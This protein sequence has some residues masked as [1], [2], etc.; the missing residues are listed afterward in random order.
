MT[1]VAGAGARRRPFALELPAVACTVV[2]LG[3][4]F[5]VVYPLLLVVLESFQVA[6][7]GQPARYGLDGWRAAFAEPL[8]RTALLNTF[9]VT[10]ARQV[11]SLALAV[12]IAWLIARTDLPGRTWIEFAFWGA[13]FLPTLTV[14]LSWILLLDPDYG[15]INTGLA[16]LP[17]IGK[18][19]FDIYSFWG[20]VW[21]HVITGSL[22]VKVILLTPAFRNMNAAF[23]EASRVAGAGTT[24]TALS[25]TIP[26]MAPVVLSV[27]LL[28]TMVSL[29]TFE[30]EQVL[31]VPFRFFVFSTMIY[32]LL[33][34]RVP[35]Y[36]A[37]TALAVLVL[38]AMLPLG[39]TPQWLTRGRRYTT[40]T[41][42]FQSRRH[43]LGRWRWPAVALLLAPVVIVLG[44]PL[45][46]AGL[47]ALIELFG[48]FYIPAPWTLKN[49]TTVLADELFLRSLWNTVVLAGS[50]AGA[51]VLV[52]SLIAFIVVRTRFVGRRAVHLLSWVPV[53]GPGVRLGL[54]LL[55]LFLGVG[56][57]RPP[58]GSMA[59]LG[60]A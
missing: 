10:L 8:L 47:G 16:K 43:R 58:F 20:I 53:T 13:F 17:V 19:P 3:V 59:A 21:I 40:I 37:A 33:V 35:R 51:A 46:V 48:V 23:E 32:D 52:P 55:W 5:C 57:P 44:V 14:T 30:V 49:W 11:V 56:V 39:F 7:P 2:L 6:P 9:K 12:L 28:G 34:T 38:A 29:Q 27:F 1:T 42:Q 24:R 41:G 60:L 18:G 15:L 31:G 54:A 36:D 22:T 4:A 50:T 45:V 25:I 26:V